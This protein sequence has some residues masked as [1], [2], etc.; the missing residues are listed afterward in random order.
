[1]DDAAYRRQIE[2]MCSF[3]QLEATEKANEIAI[4][5]EHDFNLEKQMQVGHRPL[6]RLCSATLPGACPWPLPRRSHFPLRACGAQGRPLSHPVCTRGRMVHNAKLKLQ[7]QFKQKRKDLENQERITRSNQIGACNVRKMVDRE[8]IIV[9]IKEACKA[10]IAKAV[11]ADPKA[12][13]KLLQQ[14]LVQGMLR[15]NETKIEV[16]CRKADRKVVEAVMASASAEYAAL[17]KKECNQA[18]SCELYL[19]TDAKK[20]LP[21]APKGD[22]ARSWCVALALPPLSELPA[23]L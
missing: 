2:Q 11:A 16:R 22:G 10:K 17:I 1:M 5:T 21:A 7:G 12:Y 23:L 3:I 6:F 20:D 14:L 19:A 18:V 13:K 8:D 9:G 4:K 15:L